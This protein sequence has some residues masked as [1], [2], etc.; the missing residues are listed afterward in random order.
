MLIGSYLE[1]IYYVST[2]GNDSVGGSNQSSL[3]K[4]LDKW[5]KIL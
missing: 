5:D 3:I 4:Q 1:F 2:C